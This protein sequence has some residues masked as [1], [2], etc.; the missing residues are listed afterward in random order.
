[1]VTALILSKIKVKLL[2]LSSTAIYMVE[3]FHV[4]TWE[5]VNVTRIVFSFV[6]LD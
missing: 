3:L 5:L 4:G 2:H 6:V 1:M